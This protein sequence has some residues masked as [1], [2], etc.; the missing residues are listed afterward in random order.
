MLCVS[1]EG[2]GEGTTTDNTPLDVEIFR[3]NPNSSIHGRCTITARR[4]SDGAT[5]MW[6]FSAGMRMDSAGNASLLGLLGTL[7]A[8]VF[9]TA[10]DLSAMSSAGIAFFEDADK[11][12]VTFT[13]Q[14][15]QTIYWCADFHGHQIVD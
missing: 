5:K 9:G 13:G 14:N 6:S 15:G 1:F 12:G 10:G 11:I 4:L 3:G 2:H 8:A 7:G